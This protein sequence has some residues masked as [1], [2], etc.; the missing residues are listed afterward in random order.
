MKITSIG[1]TV[2]LMVHRRCLYDDSFGV[3]EALNET[4]YGTGLVVRGTH[5]LILGDESNSMRLTRS[6]SHELYK[7]PLISFIPSTLSF[8]EWQ[9]LYRTEVCMTYQYFFLPNGL[10]VI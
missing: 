2:E 3:G 7:Q 4:A 9:A 5:F 10:I 6:L 8:L 1:F